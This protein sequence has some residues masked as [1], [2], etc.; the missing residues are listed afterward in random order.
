MQL[1]IR[2]IN[3][4]R[5]FENFKIMLSSLNYKFDIIVIGETKLK[6]TFP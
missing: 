1:N 6:E 2:G 3:D 5:K 4:Y